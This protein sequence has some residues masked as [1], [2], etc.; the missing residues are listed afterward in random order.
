MADS[1]ADTLDARADLAHFA[2]DLRASLRVV[3]R[4]GVGRVVHDLLQDLAHGPCAAAAKP[5]AAAAL[6]TATPASKPDV[7]VSTRKSRIS[8]S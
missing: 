2:Q 3:S 7:S 1:R 5:W 4:D 8:W 6:P